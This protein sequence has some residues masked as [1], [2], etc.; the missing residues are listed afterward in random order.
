MPRSSKPRKTWSRSRASVRLTVFFTLVCAMWAQA[1]SGP[2]VL[3]AARVF[4]PKSD[5]MTTPGVI[6]VLGDKIRGMG[7]AA[8]IPAGA[9]T[10]DLGDATLLPGFRE[11]HTHLCSPHMEGCL[12][13][14]IN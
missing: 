1:P 9:R 6:V 10:I 7:P 2:I 12:S 4:D 14:I 11:A 13:Q 3:R 5:R 8:E